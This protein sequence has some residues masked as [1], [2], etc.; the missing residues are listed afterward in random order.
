M[1]HNFSK[2]TLAQ[3]TF[4]VGFLAVCF[5]IICAG[6]AA[7]T[8]STK[9]S[10]HLEKAQDVDVLGRVFILKKDGNNIKLALV[11]VLAFPEQLFHGHLKTILDVDTKHL[12]Q[13]R[14]ELAHARDVAMTQVKPQNFSFLADEEAKADAVF[15]AASKAFKD[16]QDHQIY[17]KMVGSAQIVIVAR[18]KKDEV[19]QAY[20][21]EH[22]K[23]AARVAS[24]RS[25]IKALL[26]ATSR[27]SLMAT[28]IPPLLATSNSPTLRR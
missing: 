26:E 18:N 15:R 25:S 17:K 7:A 4:F 9:K 8:V 10:Q 11:N 24:V 13:L 5:F 3:R 6:D 21:S 23:R 27:G 16:S 1:T 20:E 22:A 14:S 12:M 2:D 19:Q 28:Q